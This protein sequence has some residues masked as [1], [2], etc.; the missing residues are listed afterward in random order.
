MHAKR[1]LPEFASEIA[2]FARFA[3][4]SVKPA[5]PDEAV[6]LLSAM[7]AVSVSLTKSSGQTQPLP[8]R[9][10]GSLIIFGRLQSDLNISSRVVIYA[11][12]TSCSAPFSQ[13]CGRYAT[14][15]YSGR[16]AD[17]VMQSSESQYEPMLL[18]FVAASGRTMELESWDKFGLHA[19]E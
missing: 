10:P 17:I 16:G 19:P 5:S 8:F 7:L 4:S 11:Y 13:A 6:G 18:T 14:A 12:P 3:F 1:P 15:V 2:K 9:R